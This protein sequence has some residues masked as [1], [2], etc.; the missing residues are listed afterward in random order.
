VSGKQALRHP[1]IQL[2]QDDDESE[3]APSAYAL[4]DVASAGVKSSGGLLATNLAA[5]A[6]RESLKRDYIPEV[7]E[8]RMVRRAPDHPFALSEADRRYIADC[9]RAIEASFGLVSFPGVAFRKIPARALIAL[10]IDWWR[11][12]EPANEVQREAHARLPGA[13]RLLDTAS[14]LLEERARRDRL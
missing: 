8:I 10:F 13:I 6:E 11:G 2:E 12:L 7:S 5:M 9:L 14:A 3:W 1:I 4:G